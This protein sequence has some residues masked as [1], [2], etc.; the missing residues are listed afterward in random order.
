MTSDEFARARA[1]MKISSAVPQS[2]GVHVRVVA[3]TKPA[4]QA[5]EATPNLEDAFLVAMQ[6]LKSAEGGAA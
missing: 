2:D 1:T 5:C 6:A 4:A 3:G